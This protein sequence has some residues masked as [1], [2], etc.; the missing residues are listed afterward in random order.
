MDGRLS[1]ELFRPIH[2]GGSS[3]EDGERGDRADG[4][5]KPA[6]SVEEKTVAE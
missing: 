5:G 2:P 4:D 3:H 6:D 1:G